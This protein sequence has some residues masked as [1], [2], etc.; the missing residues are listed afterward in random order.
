LG[1]GSTKVRP[2]ASTLLQPTQEG[3]LTRSVTGMLHKYR[4]EKLFKTWQPR[5]CTIEGLALV[6]K[7][8]ADGKV[9]GVVSLKD[10]VVRPAAAELGE[11]A[12]VIKSGT[13]FPTEIKD[14]KNRS[15]L[16]G[17]DYVRRLCPRRYADRPTH[18]PSVDFSI[19][20]FKPDPKDTDPE[21]VRAEWFKQIIIAQIVLLSFPCLYRLMFLSE[22]PHLQASIGTL[23]MPLQ[24]FNKLNSDAS[25]HLQQLAAAG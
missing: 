21:G 17:R 11:G 10:C 24:Q 7:G 2:R 5:V 1:S 16:Q 3:P 4:A 9:R 12:F 25:S 20:I 14:K 15:F 23:W 19:Q 18:V 6:Y 8:K 22:R 13:P